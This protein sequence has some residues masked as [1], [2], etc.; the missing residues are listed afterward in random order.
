[1]LHYQVYLILGSYRG[2][3][4][5]E[6]QEKNV[7]FY[8]CLFVRFSLEVNG[9]RMGRTQILNALIHQILSS[10]TV[11]RIGFMPNVIAVPVI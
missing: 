11:F 7:A 8:Q 10:P 6:D 5:P 9:Q 3:A 1:M 2:Q 4:I